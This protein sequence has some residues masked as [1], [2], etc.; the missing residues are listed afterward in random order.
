[1]NYINVPVVS[2]RPL[3]T[4]WQRTLEQTKAALACGAL[5]SIPTTYELLDYHGISFIVRILANLDRK[6]EARKQ[7]DKE[8]AE[9]GIEVN[10]FLPYEQKLW[11]ADLSPTHVCLLN[12][13]NVVDHHLLMITK[14][15]ESQETLLTLQDFEA[16][17]LTLSEV[18]GLVFYNGGQDAGA[19][20]KHKH[21]Q[22]VPLPLIQTENTQ[23]RLP[24]EAAIAPSLKTASHSPST[25]IQ[26]R[27]STV[28]L[29]PFRHA[30]APIDPDC[31]LN[32]V[33]AAHATFELYRQLLRTVGLEA[34][35]GIHLTHQSGAYNLLMTRHWMLLVPRA[36]EGWQGISI[37]S[38]GFAGALL[39]RNA[40]QLSTLKTMTP[41]M[42][43]QKVGY[44]D[45]VD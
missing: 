18:D 16:L 38:L 37:N 32:P 11:V 36:Q 5:L 12:K 29:L 20:Q 28:P 1:M 42:L 2:S 19:S 3:Q 35:D 34:G 41:L 33:Q 26:D 22:L 21:L 27:I 44:S 10:P 24:I 40:E 25:T 6:T 23:L 9:K 31:Y 14:H 39:V 45:K 8:S 4:L 7:Q 15:F 17:W 13:F 43:L 30:I